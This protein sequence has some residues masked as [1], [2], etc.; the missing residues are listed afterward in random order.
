VGFDDEESG[1]AEVGATMDFPTLRFASALLGYP[2]LM[3]LAH[4]ALLR[5]EQVRRRVF[6]ALLVL[7]TM[8]LPFLLPTEAV[9]ARFFMALASVLSLARLWEATEGKPASLDALST[10][11]NFA[12][13]AASIADLTFSETAAERALARRNGGKRLLRCAAK[14]VALAVLLAA[15]STWPAVVTQPLPLVAWCLWSAYFSA[16]AVA[17]AL[18][19][20]LMVLSGHRAAEVFQTPII[21]RSP[22]DF[23]SQRWNLMFRN[24]AYRLIFVPAGG[25]K[26]A[27]LG[28]ALVFGFS[29]LVHE[30]LVVAALGHT[31]GHMAAF[32][33]LQ[34]VATHLNAW[35]R[36]RTE[37]RMPR[38]LGILLMWGWMLLTSP[39]FFSPILEIFPLDLLRLW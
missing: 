21:A 3:V 25:R 10:P 2:A 7:A 16:T 32:F 33:A 29:A 23:W 12:L 30:Y 27:A 39:L 8:S 17:D 28:S 37:R 4:A 31:G 9:I 1:S 20:G 14:L 34:G 35:S 24:A 6:G 36:K 26:R 22:I 5:G 38:P 18:S 19:G 13:F 15:L 11:T